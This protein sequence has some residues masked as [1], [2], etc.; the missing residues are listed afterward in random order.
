MGNE[1]SGDLQRAKAGD[2]VALRQLLERYGPT[3]W[4][5]IQS[6]IGPTWRSLVDADDVMQVTYLEAFFQISRLGAQDETGFVAW[7]RQIARNNLRDAIKELDR[8]KRPSPARRVHAPAGEDSY[9]AL[10]D[11][12]GATNSTPSRHVAARE[13]HGIIDTMLSRMPPDYAAVIRLYD[14]EGQDVSTVASQLGRSTGA[15][16]MLRARAHDRLRDLLGS[17][18]NFFSRGA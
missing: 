3:V 10:V 17:E 15:V 11:L 9:V 5:Q 12:L 2:P 7:L 16:H 14:L 18:S 4:S 13:A 8:Q 6:E 1:T